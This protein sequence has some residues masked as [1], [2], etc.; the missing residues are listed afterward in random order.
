[1]MRN[2]RLKLAYDGT[3]FWGYQRQLS[4]RTVQGELEKIISKV[5][6]APITLYAAGRTDSGVHAA[7]QVANFKTG[8]R[9]SVEEM[10]RAFNALLPND[11]AVSRVE[12]VPDAFHARFSARSRCYEYRIRNTPDRNVFTHR[13]ELHV[14]KPLDHAAMIA[15]TRYLP[16]ERDFSSFRAAGDSSAH[17]IRRMIDA[18]GYEDGEV[19]VLFFEANAF[20]Q[21]MI[22]IIV[23]TLLMVGRGSMTVQAF[24]NVVNA[25]NRAKAGSTAPPHALCL[26]NVRYSDFT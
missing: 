2:I 13:Y 23:G 8:T 19:L 3:D 6:N 12:Q 15:A 24:E 17:S 25:R 20:L 16:G 21:H 14:A 1:M 26:T 18:G 9:L 10:H 5:T 4:G 7:G 22:R 11:I